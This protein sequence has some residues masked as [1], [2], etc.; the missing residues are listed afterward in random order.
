MIR[1]YVAIADMPNANGDVYSARCLQEMADALSK[2]S[3]T[4]GERMLLENLEPILSEVLIKKPPFPPTT[5]I[6]DGKWWAP[7]T[8]RRWR[9]E[10]EWEKPKPPG[11]MLQWKT[12]SVE[13]ISEE[14]YRRRCADSCAMPGAMADVAVQDDAVGVRIYRGDPPVLVEEVR[15]KG[16]RSGE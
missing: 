3:G 9:Y 13:A 11:S 8:W 15:F 5:R 10:W 4:P 2:P 12:H 1:G 14:E 16:E 7:W 6:W